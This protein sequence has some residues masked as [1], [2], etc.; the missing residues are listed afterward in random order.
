LPTLKTFCPLI[1]IERFDKVLNDTFFIIVELY[2]I[3]LVR[4]LENV[5]SYEVCYYFQEQGHTEE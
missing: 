5:M 2:F 3:L 4:E 1:T